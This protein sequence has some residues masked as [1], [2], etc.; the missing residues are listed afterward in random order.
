MILVCSFNVT[1]GNGMICQGNNI[2]HYIVLLSVHTMVTFNS[3]PS[4]KLCLN[5]HESK[6]FLG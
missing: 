5:Y 1:L 3:V 6:F 4:Y 2:M